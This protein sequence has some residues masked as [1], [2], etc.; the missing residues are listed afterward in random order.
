MYIE[1]Y[2]CNNCTDFA[3]VGRF[4]SKAVFFICIF[5]LFYLRKIALAC[6]LL[7]SRLENGGPIQGPPENPRTSTALSF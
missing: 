3:A 2:L 5:V 4:V 1:G 7:V 6:L